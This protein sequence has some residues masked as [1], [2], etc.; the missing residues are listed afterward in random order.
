MK[1]IPLTKGTFAIVDD[2]DFDFLNQYKWKLSTKGYA[3][4][5]VY[6]GSPETNKPKYGAEKMHRVILKVPKGVFTDHINGNRLDNRKE[7]LRKCNNQENC[8][9]TIKKR[10]AYSKYKGVTYCKRDKVWTAQVRIN[11]KHVFRKSFK[12]EMDAV[13]A[14]DDACK[15]HF[16]DFARPNIK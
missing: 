1:Q 7:N 3:E 11:G 14:Y 13:R 4:R 10:A 2:E 6:L 15:I 12:N 9:N 8:R 16:G 5:T